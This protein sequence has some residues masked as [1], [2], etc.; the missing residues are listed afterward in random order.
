MV[1]IVMSVPTDEL[2]PP[3]S[4][5]PLARELFEAA[6]THQR[7]E[8]A[9][10]R[11]IRHLQ[12]RRATQ[13]KITAAHRRAN[14]RLLRG[15]E[16]LAQAT[17]RHRTDARPREA[18]HLMHLEAWLRSRSAEIR[19]VDE[20]DAAEES[21]RQGATYQSSD[22]PAYSPSIALLTQISTSS[23][24]Y[25]GRNLATLQLSY[26]L[27]QTG[28]HEKSLVVARKLACPNVAD[29]K[30]KSYEQCTPEALSKDRETFVWMS[31]VGG[32]HFQS[33]GELALAA[34]AFKR[35]I[36]AGGRNSDLAHYMLAW[37]HYRQDQF[38][39]AIASFFDLLAI[40]G[41]PAALLHK[42]ARSYIAMSLVD[43]WQLAP[44]SPQ[45]PGLVEL[46]EKA[47]ST[48]GRQVQQEAILEQLLLITRDMALERETAAIEEL[49]GR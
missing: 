11:Q 3:S 24:P 29:W 27:A 45:G 9:F 19:W 35:A 43:Q 44:G 40:A 46:V 15:L 20:W 2:P 23:Q 33:D 26:L 21:G 25:D 39:E 48:P 7:Y 17:R 42:E 18:L 41:E 37:S 34:A 22:G 49:L 16:S 14:S 13:E 38:D 6:K 5:S 32:S 28:E 36:A 8:S 12:R 30:A 31:L 10:F 1:P 4:E 47:L